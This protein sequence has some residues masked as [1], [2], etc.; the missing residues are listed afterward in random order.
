MTILFTEGKHAELRRVYRD[1]TQLVSIIAG[2]AAITL[3]FCSEQLLYA[4]TGD[5]NLAEKA[6]PIL[7]LYSIGNGFLAVSA[8]PYYLQY[9]K[10]LLRYHLIG[11]AGMVV[12]LIPGVIFAAT[13]FGG[14]GAGYVWMVMNGLYFG[15]WVAYVHHK[16]EPGLH[17]KWITNDIFKIILPAIIVAFFYTNISDNNFSRIQ[18]LFFVLLLGILTLITSL[19]CSTSVRS[20]FSNKY[21]RRS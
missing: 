15:T 19:V 11:N 21:L 1:S 16:L 9:S 12:V 10:G 14:V 7:R 4:W 6:G 2:S 20:I 18:S 5:L 3:T 13:H 17:I 8:F